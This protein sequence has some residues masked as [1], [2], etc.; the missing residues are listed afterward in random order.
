MKKPLTLAQ[1]AKM[2]LERETT[3]VPRWK[4][5]RPLEH[6][7]G[8]EAWQ[9]YR[10]LCVVPKTSAYMKIRRKVFK[11]EAAGQTRFDFGSS[12]GVHAIAKVCASVFAGWPLLVA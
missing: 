10:L 9:A 2:D 7:L 3:L 11:A 4:F 12:P 8:A 5:W 6:T 1:F